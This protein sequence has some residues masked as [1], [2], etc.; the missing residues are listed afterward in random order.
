MLT[1]DQLNNPLPVYNGQT[2]PYGTNV[3][4]GFFVSDANDPNDPASAT[5]N[6][7]LTDGGK[8]VAI[9]PLGSEGFASFSSS[10]LAAGAHIF[11][12]TYSGDATFSTANLTGPGPSL[13]IA[14]VPTTT[15]LVST[16]P[17]PSVANNMMSLVATVTP[18][19]VCSPLAPCP[20]GFAPA[21]RVRFRSVQNGV[22]GATVLG[23]VTLGQGVN[24]GSA[25]T[26]TAVL[27]HSAQHLCRWA[28]VFD[29]GYL[30][31]EQCWQLPDFHFGAGDGGDWN[32][33]GRSGHEY[34]HRDDAGG[35][36]QL[37]GHVESTFRCDGQQ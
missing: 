30:R 2:L 24:A 28:V 20:T 8:Q 17:N 14:G 31:S 9:L 37:C 12:A 29:H 22:K 13:L 5:G 27:T 10:T 23:V 36:H 25:L 19:Q 33:D 7:I 6:I 15:S 35:L 21:G 32:R 34:V 4:F 16:D 1:T 3:H 18:V 26:N 11:S